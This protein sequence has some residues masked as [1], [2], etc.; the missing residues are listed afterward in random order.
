MCRKLDRKSVGW[1][2][3]DPQA[4]ALIKSDMRSLSHDCGNV[5]IGAGD[6]RHQRRIAYAQAV[7]HLS[8]HQNELVTA[9]GS[10]LCAH[11][12][13]SAGVPDADDGIM[14]ELIERGNR[15]QAISLISV[16]AIRS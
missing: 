3:I 7:S 12:A 11:A 4:S 15:W 16:G 8:P 2:L 6:R 1:A 10:S 14:Q 13:A 5:G 9:S